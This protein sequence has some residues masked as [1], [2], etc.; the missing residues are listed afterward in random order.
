MVVFVVIVVL[1]KQFLFVQSMNCFSLKSVAFK[2]IVV[3]Y[4]LLVCPASGDSCGPGHLPLG[5][6]G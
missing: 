3:I 2:C 4:R 5:A 6:Q 1:G